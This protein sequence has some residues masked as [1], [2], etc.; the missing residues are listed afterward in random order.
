M[1]QD[2]LLSLALDSSS[3]ERPSKSRR[4]TSLPS[5]A[6]TI[7][8]SLVTTSTTSGS[9]LF[10]VD[11]GCRPASTHVPTADS[12]GA[13][14]NTSASGPMPTSRYWLQAFWETSTSLTCCASAEPG[15]SCDRSVPTI[16]VT[17]ARMACA[18]SGLPRARSSITR[19]SID[20]AKVTPA[21]LIT[22]RSIG[23]S[24]HGLVGSR[25]SGGV[26]FKISCS[27]PIRTPFVARNASAGSEAASWLAVGNSS[28]MSNTPFSRI[29]TTDGPARSGRQTLP[30]S[31]AFAKSS[32]RIK[33]A[34]VAIC[35]GRVLARSSSCKAAS[36]IEGNRATGQLLRCRL[37]SRR[38]MKKP[39]GVS[40]AGSGGPRDFF[41]PLCLGL[42]HMAGDRVHQ[43]R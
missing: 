17:S 22:C 21:A 1:A 39:A 8:P 38:N 43:G 37:T 3:A 15:F 41:R 10:Q 35:I 33:A 12:T 16:R 4:L 19:S 34:S 31:A 25:V 14:V 23:A 26:L 32:G 2:A 30:I 7:W 5:V 29:A 9:G 18:E 20:T 36:C 24:S 11:F 6:P 13:L 27:A 28:D 42:R 40:P